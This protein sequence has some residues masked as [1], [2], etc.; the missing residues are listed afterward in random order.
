MTNDGEDA[1]SLCSNPE[2][3]STPSSTIR[4]AV[5]HL[6]A[7]ACSSSFKL[8]SLR[9]Q[10]FRFVQLRHAISVGAL[11]N[12]SS[13]DVSTSPWRSPESVVVKVFFESS[14]SLSSNHY[15]SILVRA[16]SVTLT[17]RAQ[18]FFDWQLFVFCCCCCS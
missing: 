17:S 14:V 11:S 1:K 2:T 8:F 4:P 9:N 10:T 18:V 6:L 5:I 13:D 12:L 15:K 16:S 3:N 7:P